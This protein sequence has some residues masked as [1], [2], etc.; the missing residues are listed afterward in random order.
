MFT[1]NRWIGAPFVLLDW[2]VEWLLELFRLRADGLRQYRWSYTSVAKKN[3]KTELG[4]ALACYFAIGDE[5]PAAR[6]ACM[7]AADGQADKLFGAAATMCEMS[8]PLKAV[9]QVYRGEGVIIVPS[10]PGVRIER[11]AASGGLNDG[12]SWHAILADELHEYVLPKQV[13]T[14]QVI[15]NGTGAR[16]QPIVVQ[17]TTAGHDLETLCGQQYQY[18]KRVE[19]GEVNDDAYH[20]FIREADPQDDHRKPATWRKA[21]PSY[22]VV[23]SAEF[24]RDQ[25]TKK[26]EAVFRRYFCNQWTEAESVWVTDEEWKRCYAPGLELDPELPLFVGVDVSRRYDGSGVVCVQRQDRRWVSRARLW[27]NPYNPSDR[28]FQ[29]WRVPHREIRLH[30]MKLAEEFPVAAAEVDDRPHMGPAFGYDPAF[31]VESSDELADAGLNMVEHPQSE[32]RMARASQALYEL[33]VTGAAAHDGDPAL[34]RHL[35]NVTPEETRKG[36]YRISKPRGSRKHIDLAVAWAIAVNLAKTPPP[37][38]GRS[39]Y[40]SRDLEVI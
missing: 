8:P 4:G 28:R 5:E 10:M 26:P 30:L 16:S 37:T 13:Q 36:G 9:T 17:F 15:T 31:F 39:V 18:A 20:V 11:V 32:E 2:E 23:Q 40:E 29:E 21:N 14:W 34:R 22:G 27:E 3:G 7:A 38:R 25:L 33:L 19:A 35:K 6:I 12:P 24:Y 1:D